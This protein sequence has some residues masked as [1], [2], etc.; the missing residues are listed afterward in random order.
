MRRRSRPHWFLVLALILTLL[1]QAAPVVHADDLQSQLD[2]A[3]KD[4]DEVRRKQQETQNALADVK[5]QAEEAEVQLRIVEGEL[6]QANSQLAV[7][8]EELNVTT[9]EL[10]K[11]EAEVAVAQQ[12]Y[13]EKKAVLG[14]RIRAIRENGRVDYLSVLFGSA[15]FRDFIGRMELLSAIVRKDRELFNGITADKLALEKRQEEVTI[16]KNRLATLKSEAE[17][18]RTTI[19]AKRSEREQVS[20]SLEESRRLLIARLDEYEQHSEALTQ[21]VAELVRQMN[22]QGGPFAPIPPTGKPYIVTSEFGPRISPITGVYTPH[23]GTD[24]AIRYG[25]PVYAIESGVVIVA[26]WDDVLGYLTVIDHGGGITSWYGHSSKLL[27]KA[28]DTVTQ[29]QQIAEGGSTGWSTG[30]HVHLEIHVDGAPKNAMEFIKSP[31][32]YL[33]D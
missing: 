11:V 13:D 2:K 30:P 33:L 14:A 10:Q 16:R 1:G 17:A 15:T 22:R 8:T 6:S 4:L 27:V 25:E 20:R 23:R 9:E 29:G 24:F 18:R 3:Q 28:N 12:R 26:R 21:Q 7:L 31:V 32:T 5:F 19:T